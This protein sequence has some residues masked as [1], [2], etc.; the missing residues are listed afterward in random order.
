M[1]DGENNVFP[2]QVSRQELFLF[3]SVVIFIA[4]IR[5]HLCSDAHHAAY[6][7]IAAA[8]GYLVDQARP[9]QAEEIEGKKIFPIQV[10]SRNVIFITVAVIFI[11]CT[12]N[13]IAQYVP[14]AN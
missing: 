12:V 1:N 13:G 5:T 3:L 2:I 4:Y 11:F 9:Q 8:K 10:H 14:K 6:V 7:N